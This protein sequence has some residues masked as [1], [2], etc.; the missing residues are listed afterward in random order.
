MNLSFPSTSFAIRTLGDCSPPTDHN[1]THVEHRGM[2]AMQP[3]RKRCLVFSPSGKFF[4]AFFNH[5]ADSCAFFSE[6][7]LFYHPSL[8]DGLVSRSSYKVVRAPIK[9][10]SPTNQLVVHPNITF[11]VSSQLR[12]DSS[13]IF[14]IPPKE[15][16]T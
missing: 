12:D 2:P 5:G 6:R 15:H 9:S 13:R 3:V 10:T 14:R 1:A 16:Q 7:R 4:P 11:C 8:F